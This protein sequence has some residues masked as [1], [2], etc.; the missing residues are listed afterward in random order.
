MCDRPDI[1][2]PG[3]SHVRGTDEVA[4]LNTTIYS[5]FIKNVQKHPDRTVLVEHAT[6]KKYTYGEYI[7]RVDSLAMGLLSIDVQIGDRVGIW[8]QNR[9]EWL[10]SQLACAKIAAVLTNINPDYQ[11]PELEYALNLVECK[12]MLMQPKTAFLN[13]VGMMQELCPELSSLTPGQPLAC[14]RVPSLKHV[15]ITDVKV[16]GMLDFQSLYKPGSCPELARS[17]EETVNIQFTSGTTGRPKATQLMHKNILNNGYLI[18]SNMDFTENEVIC[19]PV[20]LYHCFGCVMANMAMVAYGCTLVYPALKFD[21]L[22]TLQA[23]AEHGCTAMYG[24]PTMFI[25]ML[26]HPQFKDFKFTTLRTGI[27]AGS[28]CPVDTMNRV[29]NDMGCK[30][31]TICYGM[32]ETS[33]VSWQ[34]RPGAPIELRCT[35]VG[36]VLPNTEC[37]IVDP[38]TFEAQPCG[39]PGEIWTAGYCL[40]KGYWNNEKATQEAVVVRDGKR[41]MRT[42][43]QGVIDSNGY[44]QIVGRIKDMIL[45]GGENI[46]PKEVE[47]PL[48]AHPDITNAAVIGVPDEKFGEQ[49]CAWITMKDGNPSDPKTLEA[50]ESKIRSYLKDRITHFKLPKYFVFKKDFPMTVSGKIRKVEMREIS[51]VE[52]GLENVGK[53]RVTSS[54][55]SKTAPTSKL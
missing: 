13:Y 11:V 19:A 3:K 38:E 46:F 52:L 42:G 51:T 7:K 30:D 18:G 54:S 26:D 15:A 28:L 36:Q 37:L 4:L 21:P 10:E 45:R 25:A 55:S 47:E 20:P 41:F 34:T 49:V 6:K 14:K 16:P 43:D 44:L 17:A 5:Q 48:I 12:V 9:T 32:T 1:V 23:A 2:T 39:V 29:I 53:K 35:T 27:M 22:V 31:V 50:T 33:P 24:V 40:M 8:M